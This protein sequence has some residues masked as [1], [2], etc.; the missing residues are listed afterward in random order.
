MRTSKATGLHSLPSKSWQVSTAWMLTA[1]LAA[2]LDAWLRLLTL[3]DQEDLAGAGPGTMRFRLHRLPARLA[4]HARRRRLRTG[5]SW[6]RA[7]AFVLAW[8]RLSALPAVTW[9]PAP[10]PDEDQEGEQPAA[11]RARGTR[12]PRSVTRRPRPTPTGTKRGE[13]TTSRNSNHH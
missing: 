7:G 8:Q 5:R 3:H 6:P 11:L 13:P 12:R 9:P 1:D 4:E 2:G 10:R